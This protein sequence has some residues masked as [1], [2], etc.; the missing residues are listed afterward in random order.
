MIKLIDE[1]AQYLTA[2][3]A[4]FF[5]LAMI[6]TAFS[7]PGFSQAA[8]GPAAPGADNGDQ[9]VAVLLF[10]AVDVASG[11]PNSTSLKDLEETFQALKDLGYNPIGL[12]EFHAFID[13]RLNVPEKAVLITFDDG[14]RDIYE[15]VLPL[16][17]KFHYPAVVFT[18]TKWFAPH[19]RPE[20]S[21]PHLSVQEAGELL[22]SGWSI[23]GHSYDGHRMIAGEGGAAG[24]YYVT[25]MWMAA[26]KRVET[27]A[28]YKAR[29]WSDICL[30]R[31][32]LEMAGVA[33]PR[34]FAHPYGA[35]NADVVEMLNEAGYTYLYM[36]KPGLN[37]RGQNPSYIYR[38]PAGR[39][40]HET[41]ALL[42]WYF[43]TN[44]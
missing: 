32:A 7:Q 5:L 3:A 6:Y 18:V 36:D 41:M 1:K 21:R 23:G 20:N 26:E 10:H 43:S 39:N 22:K 24:P 27:E 2:A 40:A 34:D 31:A 12:E 38:I 14:Y 28:E 17:E 15:N 11:N 29:V 33:E 44:R 35:F 8:A 9:A 19:P 16:T 4:V 37:R 25:R 13:G 30:D 42:G